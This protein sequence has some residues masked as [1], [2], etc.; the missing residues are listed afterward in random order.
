[1]KTDNVEDIGVN[2]RVI[3]KRGYKW[4]PKTNIKL[5]QKPLA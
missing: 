3:L 5:S 4:L 1:M 2:G